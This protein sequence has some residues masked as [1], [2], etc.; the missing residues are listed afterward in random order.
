[1]KNCHCL[2]NQKKTFTL[3]FFFFFFPQA[4]FSVPCWK[5]APLILCLANSSLS[6]RAQLTRQFL[7]TP[8]SWIRMRSLC[9]VQS[10][11]TVLCFQS[12][13]QSLRW[14]VY[15]EHVHMWTEHVCYPL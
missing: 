2:Y 1:M 10:Y 11:P 8:S 12:S 4:F 5:N 13:Y 14:N 6:L 15:A 7:R 3:S 9:H